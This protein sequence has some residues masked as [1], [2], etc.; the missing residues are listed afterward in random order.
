MMLTRQPGA[1]DLGEHLADH[2]AQGVLG[3]DVVS[4]QIFCHLL[5]PA[6]RGQELPCSHAI[7]AVL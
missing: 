7:R 6:P 3:E 5:Q 4:D 2:P 1:R